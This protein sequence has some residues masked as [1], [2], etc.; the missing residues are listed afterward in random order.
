MQITVVSIL[1]CAPYSLYAKD[2]RE[3]LTITLRKDVLSRNFFLYS[4]VDNMTRN[5]TG[6][7]K[8]FV[9][10]KI[11]IRLCM[12]KRKKNRKEE[13]REKRCIGARTQH[14]YVLDRKQYQ[15]YLNVI[16]RKKSVMK[17]SF[18]WDCQVMRIFT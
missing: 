1:Y 10:Y 4:K 15:F 16:M 5:S 18:T 17:K 13:R 7:K 11:D 3:L 14:V 12:W 8:Y 6:M 9:L 2:A